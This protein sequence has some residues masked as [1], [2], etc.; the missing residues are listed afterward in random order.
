MQV[1]LE[2]TYRGLEKS[3]AI[4]A[5][6]QEKVDKLERLCNYMN[7]CEVV[8]E[9][10]HD[11]PKS[12]SPYRVRI[13]ITLPPNHELVADSNP[14]SQQQYVE[15]D[16]VIRDAFSKAER[17]LKEQTRKQRE[18]EHSRGASAQETTALVTKLFPEGGYGF[19]KALDGEEIYFHRNSVLHDDFDRLTVGTGVRYD[20]ED[21]NNGPQATSVKIVDKP[22]ARAGKSEDALIEPPLDWQ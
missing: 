5:L 8:I 14:D 7:R 17:Q 10:V 1:A 21:G 6:I 15:L 12:G 11:R 22:G 3:D 2:T 9:K 20:V 16:T 19:I 4:E 13:D 18:F